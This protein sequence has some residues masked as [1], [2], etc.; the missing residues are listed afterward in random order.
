MLT[1][2]FDLVLQTAG[3]EGPQYAHH[4]FPVLAGSCVKVRFRFQTDE[5]PSYYGTKFNDYYSVTLKHQSAS[6]L[7]TLVAET[8]SMNAFP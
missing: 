1:G 3:Q 8:K 5:F 7:V 2:D 6:G 4:Q